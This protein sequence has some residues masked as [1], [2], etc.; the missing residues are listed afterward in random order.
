MCLAVPMRLVAMEG[1]SGSAEHGGVTQTIRLDLMEN[2]RVGDFV[3]VHAGFAVQVVDEEEALATLQTLKEL[4]FF[5]PE[6][7]PK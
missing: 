4:D 6:P 5:Q 2:P 1:N 3:L 7:S